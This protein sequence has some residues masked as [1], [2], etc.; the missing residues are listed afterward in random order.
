MFSLVFNM[1]GVEH[2]NVTNEEFMAEVARYECIYNRN[3]KNFKD[4]NKKANSWQKFGEKFNLLAAEAEVKFCNIRTAYGRYLKRLKTIP[5]GSGRDA[6]PREFQNLEWL[7]SHIA[8]RPSSTNLRPKSPGTV[9]SS[10]SPASD[11]EDN[12]S[13]EV[14]DESGAII[15][16]STTKDSIETESPELEEVNE[17]NRV[18][19]ETTG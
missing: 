5:S 4:K 12:F 1:A 6:V 7:N 18:N 11:N 3:S 19:G 13:A 15:T 16:V 9:E 8:H 10:S 14:V 2:G 17:S